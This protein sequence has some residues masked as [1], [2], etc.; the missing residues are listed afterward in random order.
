MLF[1]IMS[2][3]KH[4]YILWRIVLPLKEKRGSGAAETDHEAHSAGISA[5]C[6]FCLESL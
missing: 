6:V 1:E 5:E 3:C 2:Y 4:Q